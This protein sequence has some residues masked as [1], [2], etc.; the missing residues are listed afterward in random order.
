M[1]GKKYRAALKEKPAR[2]VAL[3]EAVS[4]IKSNSKSSFDETVELHIRLGVDYSK[5]DQTVR[6]TVSLPS[7]AVKAKKV[8]VF[9]SSPAD[10]VKAKEAGAFQAGGEELVSEIASAGELDADVAVATPDMMP[11]ISRIAR[12]LGPKGLMPNP[13]NGTITPKPAE[14]VKE[15]AA[16][17]KA[18]KMDQL[19]NIHEAVGKA[20]WDDARIIANAKAIIEAVRTARPATAKGDYIKKVTLKSTMGPSV[21]VAL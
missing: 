12:I 10:Q 11:K 14:A 13:K 17:K 7:G 5:S 1:S 4:F 20:S 18:F 16:G 8:I 2:P 9:A 3:A 6:G 19:G 21:Q 15:L